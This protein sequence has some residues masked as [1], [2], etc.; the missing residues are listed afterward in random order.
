MNPKHFHSYIRNSN[1]IHY[2]LSGLLLLASCEKEPEPLT[3]NSVIKGYAYIDERNY[4][5]PTDVKVVASGP[6]GQ[7]SAITDDNCRFEIT[8]LG[9]GSYYL[10]YSREGYGTIRQYGI[11]LFGNDTVQADY[12]DLY[13]LPP[14]G[15]A[16]PRL[17]STN[18][19]TEG[20]RIRTDY[21]KQYEFWPFRLF[22]DTENN[23]SYNHYTY[24]YADRCN[25]MNEIYVNPYYIPFPSG[26]KVYAIGYY[27]NQRDQ[28]YLDMYTNKRVFSTLDKDNHSNVISF[29]MP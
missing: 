23:V 15:F 25:Y 3:S 29:T 4:E 16:M 19:V 14:A 8:G 6:Y 1:R 26:T 10:D 21:S 24:T 11:Q 5:E 7:K 28:G 13:K 20:L 18:W 17:T 9:N 27:S 12:V 22:F 2:L